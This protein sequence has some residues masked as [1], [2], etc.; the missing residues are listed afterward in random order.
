MNDDCDL[1]RER[2]QAI[3][4]KLSQYQQQHLVQWW[5][6]ISDN[7][8]LL[9]EQ[10]IESIDFELV[11]ELMAASGSNTISETENNE[12]RTVAE[13]AKAPSQLVQIA[14]T[15]QDRAV[16]IEAAQYGEQLLAAGKIGAILV[17][18]GQGTRL[19]FPG[20]KGTF[21]IGPITDRTLF[22][23]LTEQLLARSQRAGIAIPLYVM[24]SEFTHA[25]TVAT[26]QQ[27]NFFGLNA[28]D[29]FFFQQQSMPAVDAKTGRIILADKGNIATSPNG[30]GGVISALHTAGLLDEM[31]K[32]G[33]EHLYYHQ[34]DNPTTIVC[35]PELLG[36]HA[37]RKS[38]MTT[39]VAAKKFPEEKMGAVV[40]IDD[41]TQIIEYS[42]LPDELVTKTDE[43]GNPIFW[44]GNT[45]I[46]VFSR[47][48]MEQLA[49][50]KTALPFHIAKKTVPG[51][52]ETG[53]PFVPETANSYKFERFIFDALPSANV[54][55]VVEA[56]RDREFNPVK[57][58]TGNDSPETARQ[59]L[60]RIAT[61]WLQSAGA[62]VA[63]NID[64]EIS[65]LFALDA[66]DVQRKIPQGTQITTSIVFD[67]NWQPA[68]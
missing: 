45:A 2:Q 58:S 39:K 6:E 17:A 65:P 24:T 8:R 14:Q 57:N 55:L 48:F 11:A 23:H 60:N 63:E 50:S 34:V 9:L 53:T 33:I 42:D 28:N 18:G 21:P 10:Q 1:Q 54:A 64:I 40:E 36:L 25:E 13:R 52:D 38:A 12:Q 47:E 35:D 67:K 41:T 3:A 31:K 32:R 62:I 59:A 37:V 46:H 30:H 44:A 61:E 22:Q 49:A 19:G 16:R 26:F 20:P 68:G 4:A 66:K 56:N 43:Q 51:I 7:E 5:S 15:D 27:Q 29:V